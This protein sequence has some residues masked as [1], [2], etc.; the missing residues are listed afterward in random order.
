MAATSHMHNLT[1][2][3]KRLE[4]ATSRLEDIATSTELPN[5][6]TAP[7]PPIATPKALPAV[8]SPPVAPPKPVAE[9][10]PESIEEFD[11]FLN[12]A[13]DKYVKLSNTL[14]GLV[15]Q[16][17]ALVRKGF[18]EQRRFL[19]ISTKAKKPGLSGPDVSVHHDLIKPI[20]DALMAVTDLK[21]QNRPDAMYSQLSTVADGIMVLAWV[22]LDN[23]P[24]KHVEETL[25]SAQFFGNRVLKEQK[26]K[27]AKQVEW[28]QAFYQIFRDLA[29]YVKQ[30]FPNGIVWNPQGDSAQEVA[31]SLASGSSSPAAP[32]A[33]AGG[34]PP[35]PPP[36]PPPGPPPVLEIKAEPAPAT[37]S[38]GFGAVFSELNKGES[39][40]KSLRKVDKSEMTHKN[41]SLR[42]SSTVSDGVSSGRGKSPAPG[43]KPK[44]E[45]M[46]VKKPPKKEL[47]GNKWIIEN[48]EKEQQPIEIEA[49]LTHSILISR[50][51]N[52]TIIVKGKANQV[53]IEN[54]T[55]LSL[56]VDTLVST[57]DVVKAQNFA[58]Q[59][60]GT[61]PTV[62]LDQ[63]DGA[64]IYFSKESTGAKL[65]TS[66]ST[67]VN[68]NVISGPDDDYKEVPL[69]S[70]ICSYFDESKGDLVNEIVAHAG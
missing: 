6:G 50:C 34:A 69:P 26:D 17:A 15:A 61:I 7:N 1:T 67:G 47:E 59:V 52:T 2:L 70:Q 19:L 40:T 29:E 14:G 30:Y 8:S 4:A 51:N 33:P 13:V 25:G 45:S 22:T 11:A 38:S 39:V 60:M 54:S 42:T 68:L 41:P 62:M 21:D 3:I 48:Y 65:Y 55:R 57:V 35:P 32:A 37:Q 64:Q 28:V 31:K 66:K 46:R 58:L 16:Q 12:S 43:K 56:I 20:N 10:L 23:R 5:D 18:Q 53:T 63:V 44:P 27:D 24:Y 49:S 36:P 9:P